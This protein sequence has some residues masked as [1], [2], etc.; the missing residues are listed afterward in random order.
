MPGTVPAM[1]TDTLHSPWKN[2]NRPH[3][4]N[5]EARFIR[6]LG[7]MGSVST[8]R[9]IQNPPDTLRRS[10]LTACCTALRAGQSADDV[11]NTLKK[12]HPHDLRDAYRDTAKKLRAAV[13]AWD[14]II[15][16]PT[17]ET[18]AKHGDTAYLVAP[19]LVTMLRD[20]TTIVIDDLKHAIRSADEHVA[21]TEKKLQET[22]K[23]YEQHVRA[24]ST[25]GTGLWDSTCFIPRRVGQLTPTRLAHLLEEN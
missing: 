25:P 21:D 4:A 9:R 8:R 18:I 16:D 7:R 20:D 5:G 3:T 24:L 23:N 19:T 15:A 14:T 12:V 13:K 17:P 11:L 22:K 2:A 6:Q 10:Y 1:K